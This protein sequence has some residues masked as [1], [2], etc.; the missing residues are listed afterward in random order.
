LTRLAA[1]S[2]NGW[3]LPYQIDGQPV[4]IWL[5]YA[6]GDYASSLPVARARAQ[7]QAI[8]S[9]CVN[10]AD[11]GDI[12]DVERYDATP[13][14]A[15]GWVQAR[16]AVGVD[17]S[18][19]CSLSTWP[20]VQQVFADAN[21]A[22]P[23]YWVAAYPGPGIVVPAGA[24]AHQ[25]EDAGAYDATI[26]LDYWPGIDP[27]PDPPDATKEDDNVTS[28]IV[29]NQVHVWGPGPNGSTCHWWQQIGGNP[30]PKPPWF[31][32]VLTTTPVAP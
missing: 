1:D 20:E 3:N 31:M 15:A 30:S 24:V 22:P 2:V 27:I 28:L 14:Q 21:V 4:A 19:Y 8:G 5:A 23:H 11:I 32:E 10:A 16:R 7:G 9:I 6:N 18:V 17:P 29:D 12:L 26:C 13:Q 25:Y